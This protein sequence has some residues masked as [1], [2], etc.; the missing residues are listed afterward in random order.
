MKC[1]KSGLAWFKLRWKTKWRMKM[2]KNVVR[3]AIVNWLLGSE[4]IL[5][6]YKNDDAVQ[7]ELVDMKRMLNYGRW[8]AT[9]IND[10]KTKLNR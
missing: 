8:N 10:D 6:S 2:F 5:I 4:L 1:S 3:R 7:I 9:R